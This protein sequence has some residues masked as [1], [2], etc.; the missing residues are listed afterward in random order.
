MNEYERAL[1]LQE[2]TVAHRRHIHRNAEVGLELPKTCAYVR[3]EMAICA[4]RWLENN[5]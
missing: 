4:R 3:E 2:E 5:A 1:A